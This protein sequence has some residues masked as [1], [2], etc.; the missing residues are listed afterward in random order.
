M[1]AQWSFMTIGFG[2]TSKPIGTSPSSRTGRIPSL[3]NCML[4]GLIYSKI[5]IQCSTRSSPRLR[6]LA[7]LIYLAC[8]RAGAQSWSPSY[9]PLL[10]EVE[11][12]MSPLSTSALKAI[13]SVFVSWSFPLSLDWLL[14][15]CVGPEL[16][17]SGQ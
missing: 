14:M 9:V 3:H 15:I 10:G 1:S 12:G 6:C 7:S 11:M 8:I 17:L 5:M 2:A 4:I 16:S 13:D